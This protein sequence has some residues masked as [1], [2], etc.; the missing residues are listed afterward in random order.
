MADTNTTNLSLVKPEVGASTDSWGTKLNNNLDAVDAIFSTSGTAVSMGAVTFGGNVIIQ[1]TTPKLTVG[2][3]GE[4]DIMVLYDGNAVDFH[5]GIDDSA[6]AFLIGT[7]SSLGT[8]PAVEISSSRVVKFNN[9]Y[10]FPTSDGSASQVLQTDG[11]GALSF[12]TISGGVDG[13]S[14]SANATALTIDSSERLFTSNE[15]VVNHSSVL[16]LG[17]LGVRFNGTTNNGVVLETTR[18]A[19]GST[20]IRF[21]D[22][23][24]AAIGSISQDGASTVTY[25]TSSDY[26]LKENVNYD[27]NALERLNELKPCRFNFIKD[28]PD[29]VVD[30]FLAHEVSPYVPESILGEKDAVNE[31][32]S[33]KPQGIDQSKIVPLLVKSVQE[34]SAKIDELESQLEG[35]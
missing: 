16:S 2:D 32:G 10:T 3:G 17:K 35:S 23:D 1:G 34:L 25:S 24:S 22:S 14:T 30:G 4:E 26:R 8:N 15:L 21:N 9:A 7:G 6:D 20:Y 5:V 11:S 29:R 19:T 27:F 12:A 18:D 28:G 33:I 13:I 31:D